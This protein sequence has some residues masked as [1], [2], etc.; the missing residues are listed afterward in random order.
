MSTTPATTKISR[1]TEVNKLVTSAL[2][3]AVVAALSYFLF[4]WVSRS[5][6]VVPGLLTLSTFVLSFVFTAVFQVL[7]CPFNPVTVSI[8]SGGITA[9]VLL[10]ITLLSIPFTGNTLTWVVES[11]FPYVPSTDIA[12]KEVGAAIDPTVYTDKD[13]HVFSHAYAYWMFWA[14]LLPMYTTLGLVGSC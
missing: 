11:A 3:A 5:T 9:F 10:F 14:A 13:K 12:V 4:Y 7:R 2:F 8:S 6:F 1:P